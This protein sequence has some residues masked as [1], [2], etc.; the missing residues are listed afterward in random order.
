MA[1][2]HEIGAKLCYPG[3]PC[4][5]VLSGTWLYQRALITSETAPQAA[6]HLP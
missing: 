6:T 1:E 4:W 3:N 2:I 5:Q